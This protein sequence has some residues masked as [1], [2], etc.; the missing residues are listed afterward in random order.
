MELRCTGVCSENLSPHKFALEFKFLVSSVLR[1]K[2]IILKA[3]EFHYMRETFVSD[4]Y[5]ICACEVLSID[6]E[7]WHYT[8]KY[9]YKCKNP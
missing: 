2:Y 9:A 3:S 5:I 8:R 7:Q 1:E 4:S 6:D